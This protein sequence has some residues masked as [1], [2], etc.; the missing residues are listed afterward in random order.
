MGER[1]RERER[2]LKLVAGD[3]FAG[4]FEQGKG[5]REP[6]YCFLGGFGGLTLW[7]TVQLPAD[8]WFMPGHQ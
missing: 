3:S 1:G 5:K 2:G 4:T 7:T 8:E 6:A